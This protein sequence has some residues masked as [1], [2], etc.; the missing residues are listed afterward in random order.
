MTRPRWRY[1]YTEA[2][3]FLG[4]CAVT[5]AVIGAIGAALTGRPR[6]RVP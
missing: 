6:P 4:C 5:G 1:A 3:T 2:L